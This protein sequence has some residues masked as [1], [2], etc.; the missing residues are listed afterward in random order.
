[1][2]GFATMSFRVGALMLAAAMCLASGIANAQNVQ[3]NTGDSK[4]FSLTAKDKNNNVIR[5]WN[6]VGQASTITVHNSSANSDSSRQSWDADPA[7]YSWATVTAK[8]PDSSYAP[9][10]QISDS[11]YSIPPGLFYDGVATIRFTDTKAEKDVYIEVT[12]PA[13]YDIQKQNSV[14][15]DFNAG[16]T[17]SYLVEITSAVPGEKNK[18]Y[19]MRKYEVIVTPRDRYLNVTDTEIMTRFTARFPGEYDDTAPGLSDVF[20]GA[21]PVRNSTAINFFLASRIERDLSLNPQVQLQRLRVYSDADPTVMGESDEYQVLN[22]A[23]K[24]FHLIDPPDETRLQLTASANLYQFNWEK[25]DDPYSNVQI[26]PRFNPS[27]IG[28][29]VVNYKI[30]FVDS[31]SLARSVTYDSY[32]LGLDLKYLT[33]EG[34]LWSI[35]RQLTGQADPISCTVF[36]HVEATDGLYNTRSLPFTASRPGHSLQIFA[37]LTGV[38]DPSAPADCRLDQ[39]Y[40][41]PFNPSTTINFTITDMGK[42]SLVVYDLLGTPVKTLVDQAVAPGSYSIIWDATDDQ[43]QVVPSGTYVCRMTSGSSVRTIRMSLLK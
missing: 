6:N 36:W 42:A 38:H 39:N 12:Y 17:A 2:S 31:I 25:S 13:P 40:P 24:V 14:H 23:P 15:M 21:V 34:D 27:E 8:M 1:M 32:Q 3:L 11:V 43:G 19:F 41:N 22:H 5:D 7:N 29:D 10:T 16:N 4:K 33:N 9:L 20:S 37:P 18:V 28:N 30:W 35:I 26:S